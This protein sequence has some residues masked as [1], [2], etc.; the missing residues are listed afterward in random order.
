MG[1][2][3]AYLILERDRLTLVDTGA[4]GSAGQILAA[5]RRIGAQPNQLRQIVA[6]HYHDDHAGSLAELVERTNA[7]VL[8]H[9]L[10]AP[11]V[12][13]EQPQAPPALSVAERPIYEKIVPGVPHAPPARVDIELTD[14]DE[15]DIDGATVVVEAPGHTA[16]SIAVFMKRKRLLLTGDA[17]ASI[18]G[19]PIVG[20]FN[21]DPSQAVISFRKLAA[22][23]FDVALFGHGNPLIREA[24]LA[25]RRLAEKLE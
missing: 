11:V 5:I 18:D 17:V 15:I 12:R 8:V 3:Q 7:R 14:G 24:S 20:V 13:G 9:R 2:F 6:T 16:G 22:L 10:D 21:E 4:V 19:K 1:P 25:F 23:E